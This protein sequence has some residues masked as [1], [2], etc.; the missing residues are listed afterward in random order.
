M[1]HDRYLLDRVSTA[2]LGLDGRGTPQMYADYWQWEQAGMRQPE[3]VAKAKAESAGAVKAAP[4]KKKL[5][6]LEAREWEQMEAKIME[7]ELAV[8]AIRAEMQSPDVVSDGP[9][10]Q[11]CYARL[12]PAEA[13]VH[14]LYDR[15]AELEAKQQ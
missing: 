1:T 8:E 2:V 13:L 7:A 6:Y 14:Q 9:R 5:S 11:S 4:A 3:L 15:W 10:L 12:Q